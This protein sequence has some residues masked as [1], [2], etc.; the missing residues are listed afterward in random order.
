MLCYVMCVVYERTGAVIQ[1]HDGRGNAEGNLGVCA[2]VL[3]DVARGEETDRQG[4]VRAGRDRLARHTHV[5]VVRI[6]VPEW[7]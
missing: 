3:V 2:H 1:G 7:K 5:R 6:P 4:T